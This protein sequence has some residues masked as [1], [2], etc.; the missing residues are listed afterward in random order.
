MHF[1]LTFL[2]SRSPIYL[3]G[4]ALCITSIR[5]SNTIGIF[6]VGPLGPSIDHWFAIRSAASIAGSDLFNVIAAC[7]VAVLEFS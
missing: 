2:Q 1:L 4:Q 3:I 5:H 6:I 7:Q